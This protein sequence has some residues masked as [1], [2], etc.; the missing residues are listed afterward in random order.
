MTG[1]QFAPLPGAQHDRHPESAWTDRARH[2]GV[3]VRVSRQGGACSHLAPV[4]T[5]RRTPSCP[6]ARKPLDVHP[7]PA[8][9]RQDNDDSSRNSP[10]H[11]PGVQE[12]IH[13]GDCR[14]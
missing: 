13:G 2:E 1:I 10:P 12:D 3:G 4:S 8:D 5:L 9:A 11:L 14:G 7:R 6:E